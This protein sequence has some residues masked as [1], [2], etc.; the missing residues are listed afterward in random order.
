MV[1]YSD[2]GHEHGKRLYIRGV[3]KGRLLDVYT[4]GV[5]LIRRDQGDSKLRGRGKWLMR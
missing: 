2:G 1:A 5:F 3:S 4:C